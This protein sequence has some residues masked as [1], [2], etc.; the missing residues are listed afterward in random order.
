MLGAPATTRALSFGIPGHNSGWAAEF[1][2]LLFP[3]ASDSPACWEGRSLCGVPPPKHLDRSR[4]LFVPGNSHVT[5]QGF[6][7]SDGKINATAKHA[8]DNCFED[9]RHWLPQELTGGNDRMEEKI[10]GPLCD[11]T[12]IDG[13]HKYPVI[14]T[15]AP[16]LCRGPIYVQFSFTISIL[17][18]PCISSTGSLPRHCRYASTCKEGKHFGN[19]RFSNRP[20]EDLCESRC[21]RKPCQNKEPKPNRLRCE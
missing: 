21:E 19:G 2:P 4:V 11:L 5:V 18:S 12:H 1:V 17:L 20:R 7:R 16:S 3:R 13:D 8:L 15:P 9:V 10:E 6:E 14:I